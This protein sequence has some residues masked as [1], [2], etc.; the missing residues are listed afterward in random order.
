[1]ELAGAIEDLARQARQVAAG[2]GAKVADAIEPRRRTCTGWPGAP[3]GQVY[4]CDRPDEVC[5]DCHGPKALEAPAAKKPGQKPPV[6]GDLS[7]RVVAAVKAVGEATAA[8]VAERV[9]ITKR[10]SYDALARLA[11]VGKLKRVQVGVYKAA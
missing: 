4:E 5:E 10:A 11:Q 1:M 7:A 6:Y 2:S 9:G 8:D 3:K